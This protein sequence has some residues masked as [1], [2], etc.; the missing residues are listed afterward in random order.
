M[1]NIS[2][3]NGKVKIT[4]TVESIMETKDIQMQLQSIEKEKIR[5]VE[6]NKSIVGRYNTLMAEEAQL[7][8]I[9]GSLPTEKP[10]LI[11]EGEII[12]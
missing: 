7:R 4:E 8:A 11:I 9:I 1:K 10:E 3:K 6:Q 5:L 2:V 12:V